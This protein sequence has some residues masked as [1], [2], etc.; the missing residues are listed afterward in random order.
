MKDEQHPARSPRAAEHAPVVVHH[1]EE[2][3]TLLARWLRRG[4][5]QGTGFWLPVAGVAT[6]VIVGILVVT[7]WT[8]GGSPSSE[9]WV[10]LTTANTAEDRLKVADK[11]PDTPAA[12]WAR[13]QVAGMRLTEAVE[14][15]GTDRDGA[16]RLLEQAAEEYDKVAKSK[17]AQEKDSPL[18]R[19]VALGKARCD[20]ARNELDRAAEQY[21]KIAADWPT[22]PEGKEAARLAER[23]KRPEAREF[24]KQLYAYNP[25]PPTIPPAGD[26]D[27]SL[28]SILKSL[29]AGE[30]PPVF[31]PDAEKKGDAAKSDDKKGEESKPADTKTT[32]EAP[33]AGDA[34]AEAK[35]AAKAKGGLPGEVFAPGKT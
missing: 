31:A 24:Y 11:F 17:A 13:L 6:L 27:K 19:A 23:L 9:A 14:K 8:S 1:P 30:L 21:Q 20:E 15:F 10:D 16:I 29:N 4:M 7:T 26:T 33:K 22:T 3:E 12:A 2:D 28:D 32:P 5:E 34:K 35:P 18:T 25:P